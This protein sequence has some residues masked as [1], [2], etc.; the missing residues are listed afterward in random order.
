MLGGIEVTSYEENGERIEVRAQME[1]DDRADMRWVELIQSRASD[2]S[3]IDFA[4]VADLRFASG[5]AQ[6][7]RQSRSRKIGIFANTKP[8]VALGTATEELDRIVAEV[9]LPEGYSGLYLGQARRMQDSTDAIIF[10]FVL[11]LVSL[12]MILAS[13]FNSFVQ[14]LIVMVTAPLSFIGAFSMLYFFNQPCAHGACHEE[15]HPACRPCKSVPRGRESVEGRGVECRPSATT[16]ST[17]DCFVHCLGHG[18]CG[19]SE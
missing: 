8:G 2:R 9:G 4:N 14:P 7:E 1:E 12:Y 3:L 5:P 18:A 11:A 15:W 17:N 6:I 13:L 16:A 19:V 10:A